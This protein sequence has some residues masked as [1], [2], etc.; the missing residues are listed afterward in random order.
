MIEI[1]IVTILLS[2]LTIAIE[3]LMIF[4]YDILFNN[5][6]FLK[7]LLKILLR[8]YKYTGGYQPVT[9]I[10]KSIPPDEE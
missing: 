9:N 1:I 10:K 3:A 6:K 7:K 2:T 8:T 5:N 4:I